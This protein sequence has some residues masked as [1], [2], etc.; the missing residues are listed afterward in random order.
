MKLNFLFIL[1]FTLSCSHTNIQ[2]KEKTAA[3]T[4]EDIEYFLYNKSDSQKVKE[5]LNAPDEIINDQDQ[6]Y[7][8]YN[9]PSK[10]WQKYSFSFD[11]QNKLLSFIYTDPN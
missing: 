8:I 9:D 1:L 4:W 7:W 11:K 6:F 2:K 10:G 5:V 3:K